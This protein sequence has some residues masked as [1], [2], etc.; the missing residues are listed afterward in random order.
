MRNLD[1][2]VWSNDG[3]QVCYM[4]RPIRGA[5]PK[6]FEILLGCYACDAHSVFHGPFRSQK[7]DRGTFRVLNPN[8]GIDASNAYFVVR[9]IRDADPQSF[10]VLD[11]ALVAERLGCFLPAGYAADARSVWFCSLSGV[12]RIK[13]ADSRSFVSLGNRFGYDQKRVYFE[14]TV[15]PDADRVTWRP[16]RGSLS[17]DR[18]SVFCYGKRVPGVDRAS[19][20]LLQ[21]DDC[22][23]D[24]HR[25]YS[26]A[27]PISTEE[28]LKR[29]KYKEDAC[30]FDRD[31]LPSGKLFERVLDEWPQHV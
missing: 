24:R 29:L 9:P 16:W 1:T 19:I 31:W 8:F 28:Y 22:F 21:V 15:L 26:G 7:I 18:H 6:T 23:M 20:W 13:L 4:G 5:D 2:P 12:Y 14:Q 27:N 11:S 17:V 10:R 3:K 25:I 30:A